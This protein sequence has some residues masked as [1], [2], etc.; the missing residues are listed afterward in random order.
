MGP[1]SAAR[2][3]SH[4]PALPQRPLRE[5]P[6]TSKKFPVAVLLVLSMCACKVGPNYKRPATTVPDQYRG[7]PTPQPAGEQFGDMKWWAVFQDEALQGLIK[8]ALQ[9]NYDLRIAAARV[10]QAQA[11]VVVTKANQYPTLTGTGG[12]VNE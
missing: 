3:S 4:R 6:M 5:K 1:S 8:Q 2:N 10:L 11:N 7:L 12:I 9:N